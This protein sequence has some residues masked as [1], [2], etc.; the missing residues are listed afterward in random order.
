MTHN[1]HMTITIAHRSVELKMFESS[2]QTICARTFDDKASV[3]I[4]VKSLEKRRVEHRNV[5]FKGQ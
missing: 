5:F 3:K 1:G 4:Q 2:N